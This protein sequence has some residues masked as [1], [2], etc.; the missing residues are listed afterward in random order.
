[1]DSEPRVAYRRTKNNYYDGMATRS[2]QDLE[3]PVEEAG[4][5]LTRLSRQNA[6]LSAALC[7]LRDRHHSPPLEQDAIRLFIN[8]VVMAVFH[9]PEL[10]ASAEKI[11]Q[12]REPL[13]KQDIDLY[14]A[15]YDIANIQPNDPHSEAWRDWR[16]NWRQGSVKDGQTVWLSEDELFPEPDE[17]KDNPNSGRKKD[18]AG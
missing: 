16:D 9:D 13:L 7:Y 6:D 2:W 18:N 8:F 11:A 14:R 15:F 10:A 1:M 12:Y 17:E 5:L 3:I 4:E